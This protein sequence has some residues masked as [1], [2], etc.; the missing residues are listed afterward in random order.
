VLQ[1]VRVMVMLRCR[2][3]TILGERRI[4]VSELMRR[5]G[6]S[7]ATLLSLYHERAKGISFAVLEKIC[8][9]LNCQPGDLLVYV[10]D[11]EGEREP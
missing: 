3:S 8:K 9:A 10:P 7:K 6:V 11:K 4:K 5:S 2:L 1:L